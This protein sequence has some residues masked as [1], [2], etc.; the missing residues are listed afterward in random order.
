MA[1]I[2]EPAAEVKICAQCGAVI[3]MIAFHEPELCAARRDAVASTTFAQSVD[4][5]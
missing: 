2:T 3:R 1:S 4:E 5:I